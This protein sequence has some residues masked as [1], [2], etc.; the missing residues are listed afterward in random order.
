MNVLI[1]SLLF[2]LCSGN[3]PVGHDGHGDHHEARSGEHDEGSGDE[4]VD[5]HSGQHCT[6]I[7]HYGEVQ[8]RD[9]D[10][11]CC[12]TEFIKNCQE[13]TEEVCV[14]VTEVQCKAVAWAECQ[15]QME[16]KS[17][18][19]CEHTNME[20]PIKKC[21]PYTETIHHIK[22]F[23]DCRN[24]TKMNCVTN[25]ETAEDGSQVWTG[26]DKCTPVTWMECKLVEKEVPFTITKIRC[27]TVEQL[28]WMDC[29]NSTKE[30]MTS[31][32]KCE[33]KSSTDCIPTVR[34]DCVTVAYQ[35]CEEEPVENCQNKIIKEPF[36]QKVHQKKCL[37][38]SDIASRTEEV[39]DLTAQGSELDVVIEDNRD[40]VAS[41]SSPVPRTNG[42]LPR[43]QSRRGRR[44]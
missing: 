4:A 38:P 27:E 44:Q 18:S 34:Q 14:D 32:M 33:V 23:P 21:T 39:D 1:V 2:G 9:K 36:Q 40:L 3:V 19:V 22:Q 31:S 42:G 5:L 43:Y 37:L 6:D 8:Y 7:S 13:R 29:F 20:L 35:E 10:T 26:N 28:P 17:G 12:N 16:A 41:G 30:E 15:M 11:V 25:W 24:I